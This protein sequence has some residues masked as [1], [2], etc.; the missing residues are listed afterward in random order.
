MI[1]LLNLPQADARLASTAPLVAKEFGIAGLVVLPHPAPAAGDRLRELMPG[2]VLLQGPFTATEIR[3]LRQQWGELDAYIYCYR[4]GSEFYLQHAP[5]S[6]GSQQSYEAL[7]NASRHSDVGFPLPGATAEEFI[8]NVFADI[9]YTG[10]L[11]APSPR[12]ASEYTAL[13]ERLRTILPRAELHHIGSTALGIMTKPV[14][15]MLLVVTRDTALA[16]VVPA[17]H[18]LGFYWVDY[19]GNETRWYFRYGFPRQMHIHLVR[20]GSEE[21]RIHLLFRDRL[22]AN[23]QLRSEYEQLKAVLSSRYSHDR[24]AYGRAKSAFIESVLA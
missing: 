18:E 4:P 9:C 20:Q 15:D 8:R 6:P 19:P 21:E 3:T 10:D 5:L 17:L 23:E 1:V 14:L 22:L 16:S 12:F 7:E 2:S 11:V 13:A 24:A